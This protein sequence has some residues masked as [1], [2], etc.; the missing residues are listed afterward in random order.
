MSD[1]VKYILEAKQE[2]RHE[3]LKQ[4]CERNDFPHIIHGN[5][6]LYL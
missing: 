2:I 3:G 6:K 4:N 1:D 5:L